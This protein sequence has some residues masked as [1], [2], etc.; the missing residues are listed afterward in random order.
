MSG[1]LEGQGNIL[2]LVL[3]QLGPMAAGAIT[4]GSSWMASSAGD[5]YLELL[6]KEAMA[7]FDTE[8]PTIEEMQSIAESNANLAILDKAMIVGFGNAGLEA[9]GF[10]NRT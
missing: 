7:K 5:T 10:T 8:D 9:V 1:I 4:L 3:E 2:D 6:K